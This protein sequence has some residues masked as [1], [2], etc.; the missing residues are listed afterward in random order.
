MA[1]GK[2][3]TKEQRETIFQSLKPY[4]EMG[5][6][7]AKAC[8][9]IGLSDSTLSNWVQEDEALGMKLE[10]W[11]NTINALALANIADAIRIEGEQDENTRKENSWKWAEKRM[12]EFSDKTETEINIINRSDIQGEVDNILK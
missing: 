12:K 6:S 9:L 3:W 7:R 11:E 10:G 2:Q 5:F 4:L 8:K 1:Q